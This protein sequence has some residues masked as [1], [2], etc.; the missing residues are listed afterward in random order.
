Y[1]YDLD[2][3]NFI[4]ETYQL[5]NGEA[6][7]INTIL[8][9]IRNNEEADEDNPPITSNNSLEDKCKDGIARRAKLKLPRGRDGEDGTCPKFSAS[10][11]YKAAND[12]MMGKQDV[13]DIGSSR[14]RERPLDFTPPEI[15]LMKFVE[16]DDEQTPSKPQ[17]YTI[18]KQAET[19]LHDESAYSNFFEQIDESLLREIEDNAIRVI[20]MKKSKER[21][22]QATSSKRNNNIVVE[23][24]ELAARITLSAATDPGSVKLSVTPAYHPPNRMLKVPAVLRSPFL[25]TTAN[26]FKCSK[27][28]C[29]VYNAVC[30]SGGRSTRSTSSS[31]TADMIITYP[32]LHVFLWDLAASVKPRGELSNTVAEAG[33]YAINPRSQVDKKEVTRV[34]SRDNNH[35]DHRDLTIKIAGH[36]DF[37]HY[38]LLVLNL[39]CNRF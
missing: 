2:A 22:A 14:K 28:V 23:P 26:R 34:F 33:L 4:N 3:L 13:Q 19:F 20:N 9:L 35:L 36:K 27:E 39:R 18:G 31:I 30:A 12:T 21:N 7:G 29:E 11:E 10:K 16:C 8:Q 17:D 32:T 24:S 25:D 6:P 38:F 15:N 37:G 5:Q 1:E